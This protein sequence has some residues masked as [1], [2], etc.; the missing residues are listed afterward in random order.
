LSIISWCEL[1]RESGEVIY[2]D[3]VEESHHQST[4]TTSVG[5]VHPS[6]HS[7]LYLSPSHHPSIPEFQSFRPTGSISSLF[8][9]I[10]SVILYFIDILQTHPT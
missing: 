8:Y 4:T 2:W 10:F 9:Y 3:L 7:I 6:I 1:G 5:S